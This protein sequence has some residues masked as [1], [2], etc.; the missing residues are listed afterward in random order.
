MTIMR[1]TRTMT[2]NNTIDT[3]KFKIDYKNKTKKNIEYR[4]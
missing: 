2:S 3:I 4:R 1:R